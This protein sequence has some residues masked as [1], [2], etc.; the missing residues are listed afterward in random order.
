MN[1]PVED[2]TS[3]FGEALVEVGRAYPNVVV[4]DSDIADS[5]RTEP[6]KAAFPERS[7]DLG[8]AEQSLPTFAA[9]LALVGKIP[10]YN[11]FAAF[12]VTR[13]VDM[14]RQSIA[15]NRANVK[16]VGHAAGQSMGYTGPSHHTVEDF[17]VLRAIPR[18]TILNP[19]D[20]VEARQMVWRMVE[21][22][23]PVYLRLVRMAVPDPH[24][25]DY[26]FEIGKT[27]RLRAGT[28]ISIFVTG[29]LVTLAL[30]LHERLAQEGMSTQVINVPTIKPLP[31]EE[32]VRHGQRTRAAL[33]IEDH[34]IYGGLGSAIAEIYAENLQKPLR[35]LGIPDT[36]TESDEGPVLRNAYGLSLADAMTKAQALLRAN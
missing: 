23:G 34:N 21:F 24:R 14:I 29:D 25:P 13:G 36:F 22:D 26:R 1:P 10:F 19:C 20:A 33:T 27:E 32:I 35:R 15:Y 4:L 28:D 12:S 16:I 31:A 18:L 17:S 5:C 9:G 8:V 2:I 3:A 11:S 30:Q 6:F 7:F